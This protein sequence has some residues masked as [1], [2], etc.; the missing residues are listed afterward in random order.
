MTQGFINVYSAAPA[1]RLG[2]CKANAAAIA[3]CMLQAQEQ[4]AD[5][6]ALPRLALTGAGCG[7]LFYQET[8]CRDAEAALAWLLEETA[9]CPVLTLVGLPVRSEGKLYNC[10]AAISAGR[11]LA[12][13]PQKADRP[14]SMPPEGWS[15][16]LL[17]N[18]EV[19]FGPK[20]LLRSLER[21]ELAVGVDCGALSDPEPL[22]ARLTAAG[23][24]IIVCPAAQHESLAAPYTRKAAA[25]ALSAQLRCGLVCSFAGTGESVGD[26]IC[27]GQQIICEAGELLAEAAP[28]AAKPLAQGQLDCVYLNHLRLRAPERASEDCLTVSFSLEQFGS[29]TRVF[30]AQPWLPQE[31]AVRAE[32]CRTALAIQ[33][34]ALARRLGQIKAKTALLGI[35]GGLD[36][37][38]ALVAGVLAMDRLGRDRK[39][40]VAVTMPGFGTTSR[41]RGNAEALCDA[42]G[43]T[44]KTVD[45]RAAVTQHFADIGQPEGVYDVTYEN[46]Q[47]RERTQVLMDLANRLGGIVVGT[48]DMSELALGWATYNGDHMS[49]YCVNGGLPK[50]LIRLVLQQYAADCGNE[51]VAA[52][53]QDILDTPVSPEL[54]PAAADGTIAQKTEDLV[55][56]YDLHDFFLWGLLVRGWGPADIYAAAQRTFDHR[57]DSAN[58]LYWLRTFFRRFVSQQ[59]KR[60]CLPE[61]PAV[62]GVSLSPRGGYALPS[63]LVAAAWNRELDSLI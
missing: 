34:A 21:P 3:D 31:P 6:L 47:A 32:A 42:L 30:P 17:C 61:G 45:I 57:F 5:L 9:D 26:G 27:G 20:I 51:A 41:T 60:S 10:L 2:D 52:V 23:A 12:L 25:L 54:L 7:D 37:T 53:L 38:L 18:E 1:L 55:G 14:F 39:D 49:M 15:E 56:P 58:I 33:S 48:G 59:F 4:A 50:T 62:L 24:T 44:L 29:A 28:F 46:A 35:S 19:A 13:M 36:S 11:L 22:A 63:D 40:L 8:L 43:V 16:V